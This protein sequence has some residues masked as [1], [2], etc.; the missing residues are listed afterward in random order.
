MDLRRFSGLA[1]VLLLMVAMAGCGSTEKYL[2]KADAFLEKGE[3]SLALENYNKAIME[4]EELQEAYR[5]AGIAC[6]KMAD[7]ERAEDFFLRALKE[8]DGIISD[9]ELDLSYYLGE[10]QINLGKYKDAVTTYSN[11]L[12]YDKKETN[13]YFYRGCAYLRQ[14]EED[15]AKKDF[16]KAAADGDLECLYG[17]YE[18]YAQI[19]R[20]DGKVYLEQVTKVKP[21]TAEDYYTVGKAYMCLG[22]EEKAVEYLQKS[23]K[24]GEAAATFYLGYLYDQKGDYDMARTYYGTYKEKH[25]LTL[26]EYHV[27]ADCM[28]KQ[29]DYAAALELNQYMSE[30]AGKAEMQDLAFE[31][32][33]IYEKNNDFESARNAAQSFVEQ[34]PDDEEGQREYAFLQ[35][36]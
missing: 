1:A 11:V 18:A 26:G 17:I 28:M 3:Y 35:T 12:E 9:M 32:I 7:Y 31:Q 14:G 13:A 29:G 2:G 30:S 5:G 36:R 6:M 23:E 19:G 34:Y 24:D 10:A 21:Q 25:G 22:N 20:E 4:D 33:V 16:E 8:T 15:K 27:V